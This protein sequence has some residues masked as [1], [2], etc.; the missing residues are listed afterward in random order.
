[1]ASLFSF[2]ALEIFLGSQITLSGL[3]LSSIYSDDYYSSP[4]S[5]IF[6]F[7]PS[8]SKILSTKDFFFVFSGGGRSGSATGKSSNMF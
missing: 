5:F 2:R 4:F 6:F 8:L 3:N 7:L 1:M